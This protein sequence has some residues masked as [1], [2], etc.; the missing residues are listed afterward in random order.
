MR[1]S[2]WRYVAKAHADWVSGA[3]LLAPFEQVGSLTYR[4][5]AYESDE[6]VYASLRR[7]YW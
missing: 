7:R 4:V 6:V 5:Q 1:M 3:Y 2:M